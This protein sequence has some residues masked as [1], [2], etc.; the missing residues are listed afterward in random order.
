[1]V[2]PLSVLDARQGLWQER[3]RAWIACGPRSELGREGLAASSDR[4]GL[5]DRGRVLGA[6]SLFDPVLC[7]LA[8]RWFCPSG[9]AVLDPFAGGSV[10]GVVAGLLGRHY[11]GID[12]SAK[13]IEA[14]RKQWE[15]IRKSLG[16]QIVAVPP[17]ETPDSVEW[18]T[19]VEKHGAFW[20]KRDDHFV[21]AGARGGKVR[22]CWALA[23]GA[24]GLVTAGSRQSPQVNIVARIARALGVPCRVHV[25]SGKLT[26]ELVAAQEAGAELVQHR[27]GYNTVLL[28]RARAD[29][30]DRGWREIPFGMECQEAVEQTA[31]Q[32]PPKF[33]KG[34]RRLVVPVGS[35]MS[36]AGV[37]AG[38]AHQGIRLPV[39][40]VTVGAD[41]AKRLDRYAP[42]WRERVEL[43]D[44]GVDYHQS[45][46]ET[47]LDGVAL[48]PIY[49]AKCLPFLKPGALLWCVGIRP[50]AEDAPQTAEAPAP[51]WVHGDSRR[52]ITKR[53]GQAD[54]VFSCPPYFDLERYSDNPQDL[55][56]MDWAEFLEG[57]R[58]I[59]SKSVERLAADRFAVWVIGDVR[60]KR[61]DYRDLVGETCR[62]F[63][64]VGCVLYNRAVLVT[65][66]GST[67]IH[68]GRTFRAARKLGRTHQEVLVFLKG[69]P[70][71]AVEAC[72]PVVVADVPGSDVPAAAAV[73]AEPSSGSERWRTSAKWLSKR[74]NCTPEGITGAAGCHGRCCYGPT[75]WPGK[76]GPGDVCE[77]LGPS[78]CQLGQADK[79]VT[80]LLYPLRVNK[81]GRLI[82]H[83]R[84]ITGCCK[85]CYREGPP[86]VEAIR[87][88]LEELFGV[89]QVARLM[90][91]TLAGRDTWLDVPASVLEAIQRE[92]LWESRGQSPG[93]R[94]Q[95]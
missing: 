54:L 6:G 53:L 70:K 7:E 89:E 78:G 26:P 67:M 38:L 3:K 13:Q 29:A 33:P 10:R 80:C 73:Q 22:T 21:R 43:V 17:A 69:D 51:V 61:G 44:S 23:Q 86:I 20:L 59:I 49:E 4:A 11:T 14:N 32:V 28:A 19:P 41:P 57:Y 63:L 24:P 12:L 79:P 18:Q 90:A 64:E 45:A 55:S 50:S 92:E 52:A 27:P 58:E 72:G 71:R 35:G 62:A 76:A 91:E 30:A 94:G 81:A 85:P 48:D 25:P 37:L 75:F 74:I 31:S 82:V 56:S 8:Y 83:N 15:E 40:G 36:L 66:V 93:R 39:I 68:A 2:P 77:H 5:L 9:G 84:S 88:N 34:V 16:G 1:L 60:D 47:Q 65:P 87:G 46:R 95:E 42:G